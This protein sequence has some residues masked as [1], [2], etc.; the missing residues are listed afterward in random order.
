MSDQ[1]MGKKIT[2]LD[3]GFQGKIKS[4][5]KRNWTSMVQGA[6]YL[7]MAINYP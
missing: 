3:Y 6:N 4:T 1:F 2:E 7:D 5:N